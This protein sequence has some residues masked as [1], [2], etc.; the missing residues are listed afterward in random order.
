M[1]GRKY[2]PIEASIVNKSKSNMWLKINLTEG[3]NREIRNVL[4]SL[5]LEVSRL[6]RISYG[7]FNLAKLPKGNI[8]EIKSKKIFNF[9]Q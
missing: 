4:N 3:Q 6:I 7:P 1:S 5:N 8:I 2:G 9:R